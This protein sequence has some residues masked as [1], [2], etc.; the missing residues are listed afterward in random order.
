MVPLETSS[1]MTAGD[2]KVTLESTRKWEIS[3]F[4]FTATPAEEFTLAAYGLGDFENPSGRKSSR[5]PYYAALIA[6][7]ALSIGIVLHRIAISGRQQGKTPPGSGA[8]A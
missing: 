5:V 2:D 8:S 3:K 1:T 4:E 6:V 7:V